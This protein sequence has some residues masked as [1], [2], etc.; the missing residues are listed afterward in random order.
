MYSK[1]TFARQ[2]KHILDEKGMPQKALAEL[3]NT[4]ETTISRYVAGDRTPNIETAVEISRCL[5]VSMD[6]LVGVEPPAQERKSPDYAILEAA[7]RRAST[8]QRDALWSI[9]KGFGL[10][11]PEQRVI[12]DAISLEEKADAV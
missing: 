7:Y 10:L 11:T 2:L 6:T 9:L 8:D 4:T 3:I 1:A 5:N 12:V